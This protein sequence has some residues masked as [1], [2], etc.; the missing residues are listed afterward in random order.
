[1]ADLVGFHFCSTTLSIKLISARQSFVQVRK[2]TETVFGS[3]CIAG[4]QEFTSFSLGADAPSGF[5]A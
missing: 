5:Q 2:V 1:M 4:N 3:A